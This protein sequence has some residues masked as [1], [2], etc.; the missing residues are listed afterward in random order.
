MKKNKIR[1]KILGLLFFLIFIFLIFSAGY[2]FGRNIKNASPPFDLI[3]AK[4]GQPADVDFSA[5]W[6]AWQMIKEKS[7]YQTDSKQ[8]VEGA[9][10]GMMASL[11]D[12]YSVYFSEKENQRFR[13]DIQ[14]EFYGI[15]VEIIAKNGYPTIV[16]PITDY[17]AEKAGV[18]AGDI[19]LAVDGALT[20]D[21]GLDEV[22]DKI[23]G[24]DGTE[25]TLKLA[26]ASEEQPIEIKIKRSKIVIKSVSWSI[27]EKDGKKIGYIAIKQFGDDTNSLFKQAVEDIKNN[28]VSGL[29]IDLRNDP[30]GYFESSITIASYFIDKGVIVSEEDKNKDKKDYKSEGNSIL[31]NFKPVVLINGGSASASEILAGALKD[32]KGSIL[33]GEKTFGKGSVQELIDLKNGSAL[34]ITVAKWFTPSGQQINGEG[35]KPDVE[36]VNDEDLTTDEQLEKALELAGN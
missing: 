11:G 5:F 36:V 14:G 13:E 20:K 29:I 16:A 12:P 25:V 18:K 23:R 22:V 21:I 35:I 31:K 1:N 32:R 15:G 10:S 26:R 33:V 4:L 6:E 34:K 17:P 27:K 3:N 30:G 7:V 8:L 19:I 28:N 24:E 2:L 9:I